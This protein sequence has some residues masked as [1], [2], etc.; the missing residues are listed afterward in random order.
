MR[1]S[2]NVSK[3]LAQELEENRES[4]Q[5]DDA[6]QNKS[7]FENA[8]IDKTKQDVQLPNKNIV[9]NFTYSKA[10]AKVTGSDNPQSRVQTADSSPLAEYQYSGSATARQPA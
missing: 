9:L 6:T 7:A 1:L 10:I 3:H 4:T 8:V 2:L 5:D